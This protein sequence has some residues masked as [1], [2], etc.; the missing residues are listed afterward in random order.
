MNWIQFSDAIR[1]RRVVVLSYHGYV[2]TVEPHCYGV[3]AAGFEKLRCWQT[4]GGSVS[5]ERAGWKLLFLNEIHSA[6]IPMSGTTFAG[7]RPGY[8]P[9]DPAMRTIYAQL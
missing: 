1:Q 2:R 7:T 9:N 8:R 3:D 5:G 6:S 4:G